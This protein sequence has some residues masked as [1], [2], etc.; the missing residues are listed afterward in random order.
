VVALE[1]SLLDTLPALQDSQVAWLLLFYCAALR[2]MMLQCCAAFRRPSM[3]TLPPTCRH[4]PKHEHRF[5]VADLGCEAPP[6]MNL[7]RTGLS[8]PT[9]CVVR[10][11]ARCKARSAAISAFTLRWSA[12]LSFA[13]ARSFA[14]SLLSLPLTGTANVDGEIPPLSDMLADSASLPPLASRPV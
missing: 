10:Q 5:G 12:P 7:L 3:P 1:A 9:H 8:G 13:A 14:A 11:L 4:Q 2:A 6:D